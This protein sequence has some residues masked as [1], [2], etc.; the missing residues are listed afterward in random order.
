MS[1]L[2]IFDPGQ[3]FLREQRDLEKVLVVDDAQGGTG[4]QP[5]DLDSGHVV[6]HM[7]APADAPPCDD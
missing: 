2:E 4:P 3:R 1:F 7:P 5:L 6:L